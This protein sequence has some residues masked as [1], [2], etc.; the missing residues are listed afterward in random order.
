MKRHSRILP[1]KIWREKSYIGIGS[2]EHS[3]RLQFLYRMRHEFMLRKMSL[4]LIFDI[5]FYLFMVKKL[6]T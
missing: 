6:L 2:N 3:N 5:A 4:G 1:R